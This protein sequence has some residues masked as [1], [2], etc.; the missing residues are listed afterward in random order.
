MMSN[1]EADFDDEKLSALVDGTLLDEKMDDKG[2]EEDRKIM[3]E[4]QSW[5]KINA[6]IVCRII[7][8]VRLMARVASREME[9]EIHF[10]DIMMPMSNATIDNW[11]GR[12]V[13]PRP[14]STSTKF[15]K[16]MEEWYRELEKK[17]RHSMESLM[18]NDT[19][20]FHLH[21]APCAPTK[22]VSIWER[23]ATR[24]CGIT[25][26]EEPPR[27]MSMMNLFRTFV[28]ASQSVL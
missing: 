25:C 4:I 6:S 13:P 14:L 24:H 15:V 26:Q 8:P 11:D 19:G 28:T 3:A 18:G 17:T 27:K 21:K 9:E 16:A 2:T 5:F 7:G 22:L 23:N 12:G 10:L 1:K 20:S